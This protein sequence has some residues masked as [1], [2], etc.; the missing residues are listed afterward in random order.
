METCPVNIAILCNDL[1]LE[2]LNVILSC[3]DVLSCFISF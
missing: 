2:K 1:P 3:F